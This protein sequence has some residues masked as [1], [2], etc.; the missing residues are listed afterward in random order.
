MKRG[1]SR[2]LVF[3]VFY[4]VFA[5]PQSAYPID[6][7]NRKPEKRRKFPTVCELLKTRPDGS[8]YRCSGVL[9]SPNEVYTAGHCLGR[10]FRMSGTFV[11][12][13]CGS[14]RYKSSDSYTLPDVTNHA[15][16][17]ANSPIRSEDFGT[18]R[19]RKDARSVKNFPLLTQDS[20]LYFDP[21]GHLRPDVSCF[22]F[23]FGKFYHPENISNDNPTGSVEG[24]LNSTPLNDTEII[25]SE[26]EKLIKIL[27]HD[28]TKYL[29][30]SAQEG[31]SGGPMFCFFPSQSPQLV[32]T[33]IG[34]TELR[35]NSRL[36]IQNDVHPVWF[37]N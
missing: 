12:M 24:F 10:D 30:T 27:P 3:F 36:S 32:G 25:Y 31:D 28:G 8:E 15:L 2:Y 16:W 1:L 14:H 37:R 18:L 19:L 21:A 26:A 7:K 5:F 22:L 6:G 34:H 29:S 33:L 13:K 11:K 20:S 9:V 35:G 17:N 4:L 23:G